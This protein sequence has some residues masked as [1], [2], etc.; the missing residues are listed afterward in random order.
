MRATGHAS[1]PSRVHVASRGT[2]TGFVAPFMP[3][4]TSSPCP[5]CGPAWATNA[6]EIDTASAKTMVQG[7]MADL[8]ES[9]GL[10]GPSGRLR[11]LD[12]PP[13]RA[14]G[15]REDFAPPEPPP[16]R[17]EPAL[18]RYPAASPGR[19]RTFRRGPVAAGC[20]GTAPA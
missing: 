14:P 17:P 6:N 4:G 5:R 13:P 20:R 18:T 1:G 19:S 9:T 3:D 11:G 7:R 15:S 2:V 8:L 10:A 16:A 12:S